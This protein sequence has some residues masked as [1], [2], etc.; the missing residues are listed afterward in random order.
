MTESKTLETPLDIGLKLSKFVSPE[1]GSN[2]QRE[3]QSCD[4]W[5]ILGCLN[6]LALTSRPD[7]AHAAN[8]LISFAEN[9]G[10]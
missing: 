2:E 10:R 4:C 3:M 7:S 9:P 1:I 6:F 5:G 8:I